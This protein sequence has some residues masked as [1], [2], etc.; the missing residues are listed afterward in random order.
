MQESTGWRLSSYTPELIF[1]QKNPSVY[2]NK[3]EK[4]E[5]NFFFP[6]CST[7]FARIRICIEIR[8]LVITYT[9]NIL[10]FCLFLSTSG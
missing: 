8:S 10:K 2:K 4:N 3:V 6:I 1:F 7:K 9:K 5:M